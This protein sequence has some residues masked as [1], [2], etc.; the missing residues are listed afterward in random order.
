MLLGKKISFDNRLQDIAS[1]D[2]A[3]QILVFINDRE[4]AD[5]FFV[6]NTRDV[7]IQASR[8]KLRRNQISNKPKRHRGF[9][10]VAMASATASRGKFQSEITPRMVPSA[11]TTGTCLTA[12]ILVPVCKLLNGV[13]V[14]ELHR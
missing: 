2:Q 7:C 8:E 12:R 3:H 5:V 4:C 1:C 14:E 10:S 11:K 9:A 6:E 13:G